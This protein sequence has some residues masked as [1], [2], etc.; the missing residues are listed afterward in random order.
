MKNFAETMEQTNETLRKSTDE[1]VNLGIRIQDELFT[2]AR[3]Q[4]DSF[5]DYTEFALK[6][7]EN[8]LDQFEKATKDGRAVWLEGMKK[9]QEQLQSFNAR[10]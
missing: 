8:L 7:Q 9:W 2:M 4:M 3:K 6:N 5:R 1:C 10:S